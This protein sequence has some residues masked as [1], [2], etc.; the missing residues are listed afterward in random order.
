MSPFKESMYLRSGPFGPCKAESGSH[1]H[2][3]MRQG[4][5]VGPTDSKLNPTTS[6]MS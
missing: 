2:L 4:E 1:K 6:S 3:V 5:V